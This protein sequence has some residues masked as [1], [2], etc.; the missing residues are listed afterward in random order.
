MAPSTDARIE[1]YSVKPWYSQ[2]SQALERD[3]AMDE[4][5]SSALDGGEVAEVDLD[6]RDVYAIEGIVSGTRLGLSEVLAQELDG[7]G[8]FA[9]GTGGGQDDKMRGVR[10]GL[11]EGVNEALA[12][13]QA[14]ATVVNGS[15]Q[16]RIIEAFIGGHFTC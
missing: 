1:N 3:S 15:A 7:V 10:I 5:V 9:G 12:D 13:G 8:G 14:N 2:V 4:L 11:K 6:G 16:Y